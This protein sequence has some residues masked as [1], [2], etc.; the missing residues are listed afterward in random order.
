MVAYVAGLISK[1][2]SMEDFFIIILLLYWGYIVTFIKVL[3]IYCGWIHHLHHPPLCLL[4]HSWNSFNMFHF[5]IH[6]HDYIVFA[7]Y[8]PSHKLS[9]PPP[10]SYWYHTPSLGRTCSA[11]LFS[12][13]VNEKNDIFAC[14]RWLQRGFLCGPSMYICIIV[15]IGLS[16]LFFLFL[17]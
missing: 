3:T 17:P 8:S 12:N 2:L 13:F 10:P 6:I 4:P 11:L 15:Q 7:L 5:S 9:P 16:P 1:E 14:L